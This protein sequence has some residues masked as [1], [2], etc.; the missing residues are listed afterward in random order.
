MLLVIVSTLL[1]IRD[2]LSP[3]PEGSTAAESYL[4]MFAFYLL[5]FLAGYGSTVRNTGVRL[6]SKVLCV[7]LFIVL[8]LWS[9][10]FSHFGGLAV[11]LALTLIL[12]G[13]VSLFV[14]LS[15]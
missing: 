13:A 7:L 11:V 2:I 6:S 15:K 1:A 8:T 5:V 3:A 4:I 10:G 9:L 14:G 12:M